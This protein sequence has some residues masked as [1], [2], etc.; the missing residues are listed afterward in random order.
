MKKLFVALISTV[1]CFSLFA[2]AGCEN[3]HTQVETPN[4][5]ECDI[6][7][8]VPIYPSFEFDYQVNNECLVHISSITMTLVEKNYLQQGEL[9]TGDFQPFVFEL[10]AIGKTEERFAGEKIY[11]QLQ[12]EEQ[13]KTQYFY[14]AIVNGD[15]TI[16]WEE[17]QYGW[18]SINKLYFFNITFQI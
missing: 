1:L 10:N 7:F 12:A 11:I 2:F 16:A 18:C 17:L 6:G 5:S 8:Q 15:G 9:V 3:N 4:L 14:S 13:Y